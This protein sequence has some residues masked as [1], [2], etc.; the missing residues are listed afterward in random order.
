MWMLLG[1]VAMLTAVGWV[2]ARVFS[3]LTV[4][5]FALPTVSLCA[6]AIEYRFEDG[7]RWVYK[8][9][10]VEPPFE[11]ECQLTVMCEKVGGSVNA[12]SGVSGELSKPVFTLRVGFTELRIR[13][14]HEQKSSYPYESALERLTNFS[15]VVVMD[16][17]GRLLSSSFAESVGKVDC[18]SSNATALV[19]NDV[20]RPLTAAVWRH[21]FPRFLSIKDERVLFGSQDCAKLQMPEFSQMN[22]CRE[23]FRIRRDAKIP[24][25]AKGCAIWEDIVEIQATRQLGDD[26]DIE[27]QSRTVLLFD[28]TKGVFTSI[29]DLRTTV[30]SGAEGA[31][32]SRAKAYFLCELIETGKVGPSAVS[33]SAGGKDPR[34]S[35]HK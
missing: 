9:R 29:C 31:R 21:V 16:S 17:S 22:A 18:G 30:R 26:E 4:A 23:G 3:W 10:S 24:G 14:Q 28:N 20:I 33:D 13:F 35:D 11:M 34:V 25:G 12:V 1:G 27:A 8:L 15:Y 19:T 7:Q 32:G 2:K 5:C 6:S